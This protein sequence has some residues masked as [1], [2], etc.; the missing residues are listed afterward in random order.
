MQVNID[1]VRVRHCRYGSPP[2]S[3]ASLENSLPSWQLNIL[4]PHSPR[5][6]EQNMFDSGNDSR[7]GDVLIS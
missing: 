2:M 6:I 3:A 5:Q 7:L 4:V 1:A